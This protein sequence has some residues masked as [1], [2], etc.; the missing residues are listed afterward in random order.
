MYEHVPDEEARPISQAEEIRNLRAEIQDLRGRIDDKQNGT[1]AGPAHS[2][3]ERVPNS[4][5][6]GTIADVCAGPGAQE[7]QR[8]DRLE[9]LFDSIRSA[10]S[11]LVDDLVHDIRTA[12]VGIKKDLVPVGPWEGREGMWYNH[13]IKSSP[14]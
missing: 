4:C 12:H 7:L 2:F 14:F 9:S 11:P 6:C 1:F 3:L 10:P 8:L 5:G 13:C